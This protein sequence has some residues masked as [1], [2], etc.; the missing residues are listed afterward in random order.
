MAYLF[1][2]YEIKLTTDIKN[3]ISIGG[4][5]TSKYRY[6]QDYSRYFNSNNAVVDPN[7]DDKLKFLETLHASYD[8][9]LK[10]IIKFDDENRVN[11]NTTQLIN[12]LKDVTRL[13]QD[14]KNKE[15]V[16]LI[17]FL[18]RLTNKL[19]DS[20]EDDFCKKVENSK[21]YQKGMITRI[22]NFNETDKTNED[23][24]VK[25]LY[26]MYRYREGIPKSLQE[27]YQ[28]SE[29]PNKI[30]VLKDSVSVVT[31]KTMVQKV[32]PGKETLL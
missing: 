14:L 19:Y 11:I 32:L 22:D 31:S 1:A 6:I 17:L 10:E 25:N 29:L 15:Y 20:I 28:V 24:Y 12:E 3:I 21:S 16:N 9:K 8:E 7:I 26:D 13:P 2:D 27:P 30:Y 23:D 4:I 18:E 5:F